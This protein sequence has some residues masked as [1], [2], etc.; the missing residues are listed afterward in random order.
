[1]IQKSRKLQ[2]PQR[3]KPYQAK[4]RRERN[5]HRGGRRWCICS[6][7]KGTE[8]KLRRFVVD[9]LIH[10]RGHTV[11]CLSDCECLACADDS[12]NPN[13][14]SDREAGKRWRY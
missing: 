6:Q 1:M 2:I 8:R 11:A 12:F 4:R 7:R 13:G 9:T 14:F 5:Y 10:P 3:K